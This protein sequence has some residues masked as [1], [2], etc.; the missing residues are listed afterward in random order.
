MR[1][2]HSPDFT[3]LPGG[4]EGLAVTRP[5]LGLWP[6]LAACSGVEPWPSQPPGASSRATSAIVSTLRRPLALGLALNSEAQWRLISQRE[7]LETVLPLS[8]DYGTSPGARDLP[9]VLRLPGFG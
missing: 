4:W 3:R 8:S 5:A 6:G 9:T 2:G 7:A 1:V